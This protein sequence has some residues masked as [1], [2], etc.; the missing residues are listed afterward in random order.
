[1]IRG[2]ERLVLE[3]CEHDR[4]VQFVPRPVPIVAER[5]DQYDYPE[6]LS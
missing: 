6:S 5:G 4:V 1:M 3:P 2:E